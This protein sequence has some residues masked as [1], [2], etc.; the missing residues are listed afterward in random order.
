MTSWQASEVVEKAGL[1]WPGPCPTFTFEPEPSEVSALEE[2]SGPMLGVRRQGLLAH[3]KLGHVSTCLGRLQRHLGLML[4]L[5]C[6][7]EKLALH[8]LKQN[9]VD[10]CVVRFCVM[11][12]TS[13][14]ISLSFFSFIFFFGLC[15]QESTKKA[16]LFDPADVPFQTAATST[17]WPLPFYFLFPFNCLAYFDMI[18]SLSV[19][20]MREDVFS[21]GHGMICLLIHFRFIT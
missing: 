20:A 1:K 14:F 5:V 21:Q 4:N 9:L 10:G 6:L 12:C 11:A 16:L 19:M 17:A 15:F 7:W 13:F 18:S 2:L 8:L 3:L